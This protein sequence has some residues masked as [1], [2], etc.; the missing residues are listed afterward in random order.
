MSLALTTLSAI[1]DTDAPLAQ[2]LGLGPAPH[3]HNCDH[4]HRGPGFHVSKDHCA[5]QSKGPSRS[6]HSFVLAG[7]R[8]CNP[9]GDHP[10]RLRSSDLGCRLPCH[11]RSARRQISNA[12]LA[13][14]S[15]NLRTPERLSRTALAAPRN[16]RGPQRMAPLRTLHSLP[17]L[18]HP[19]SLARSSV[20]STSTPDRH[21]HHKPVSAAASLVKIAARGHASAHQHACSRDRVGTSPA[22]DIRRRPRRSTRPAFQ[23]SQGPEVPLRAV[24]VWR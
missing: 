3:R 1:T 5:L 18:A 13:R 16:H 2:R 22:E 15:H 21:I 7:R 9:L 20:F 4:P 8:R 6:H 10:P 12:L 24:R 23:S 11:R 19:G 14:R 17:L